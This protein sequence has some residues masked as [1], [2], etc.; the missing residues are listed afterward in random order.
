MDNSLTY[1]LPG[2]YSTRI[3]EKA[4]NAR[5]Q[6][7][8]YNKAEVLNLFLGK[9]YNSELNL[10]EIELTK[11]H[12]HDSIYGCSTDEVHKTVRGRQLS[13]KETAN[14]VIKHLIRD[15]KT[16]H[17]INKDENYI[18]VFN[19]SN[20]IQKEPVKVVTDKKIKYGQKI[21]EFNFVSDDIFYNPYQPPITED[22]HKFYEYLVEIEPIKPF[23]FKNFEIQ[24]PHAMHSIGCDFIENKNLK[25]F[26]AD[27]KICVLD[28]MKNE[29]YEDFIA[30]QSTPDAGDSY[31][32]APLE[33]PSNLKIKSYKIKTKGKIKSVFSVVFE[34]NIKLDFSLTNNSEFFEIEADFINK[35]KNRLLQIMFN[36]KKPITKTI[37]QDA[38]LE[39]EREHDPHYLLFENMPPKGKEELK[40][41]SYPMQKYVKANG[42]G[43]ITEGLN[44]YTIYENSIKI[45]L[46]RSIGIISNPKNSARKIPAGPPIECP[47]MQGLGRHKLRLGFTFAEN[48]NELS[49]AFYGPCEAFLGQCDIK[50]KHYIKTQ[51][52][53]A[54]LGVVE[55]RPLFL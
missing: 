13:V 42:V 25:L 37:A 20:H 14:T 5:L 49:D 21:R 4:E 22:F 8:L 31:N 39:I 46:L 26:I 53:K 38:V 48:I 19:F 16:E 24:K 27:S 47:D 6:W 50:D 45:T 51:N 52:K 28:K 9:K 18:G 15:F 32:F 17:L 40:T 36:T 54:F 3:D 23:S 43:I 29:L 11:N 7:L 44:E 34:E 2:V 1:I 55:G 30:L 41:N 35:K 33:Y 10:A 12:A